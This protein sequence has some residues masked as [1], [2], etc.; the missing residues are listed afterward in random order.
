MDIINTYSK[1]ISETDYEIYNLKQ[2]LKTIM[3]DNVGII[4]DEEGLLKAKEEIQNLS[5]EFNRDKKCLNQD[6]YEYRNMLVTANL[7]V[8]SALERKES[9]GAHSRSDYK[10]KSEKSEHSTIVKQNIKELVYAK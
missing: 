7:I 1:P 9:R 3:W 5:N 6:E 8:E 4:R 10:N 2:K